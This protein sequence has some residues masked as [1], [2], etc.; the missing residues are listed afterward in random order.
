[1]QKENGFYA[2][3][4]DSWEYVGFW[5]RVAATLLDSIFIAFITIP[6]TILCYGTDYFTNTSNALIQGP[7]D[8]IITYI[9]PAIAVI[10]FWIYKQATPGKMLIHMKIVDAT[11]GRRPTIGQYL[12]RYIGYFISALPL[13]LG[14]LWVAWDPK[15]QGWHDKMANTIVIHDFR[16]EDDLLSD[17]FDEEF[18]A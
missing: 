17:E 9:L 14:Y 8:F 4:E 10:L 7:A 6:L 2:D 16:D 15:K 11:T 12:I 5:T 18:R 3:K 1:M 13:C